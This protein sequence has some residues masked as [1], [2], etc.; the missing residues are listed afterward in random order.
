MFEIM[1]N[2]E[3]T[4]IGNWVDILEFAKRWEKF[5]Q[6]E[7]DIISQADGFYGTVRELAK[8]IGY[9][10]EYFEVKLAFQHLAGLGFVSQ[11]WNTDEFKVISMPTLI[12]K[13]LEI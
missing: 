4:M 7:K 9:E 6:I 3:N 8:E 10:D 12:N 11:D 13:I 2:E 1:N 5:T